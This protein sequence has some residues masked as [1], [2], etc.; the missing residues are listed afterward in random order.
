MWQ[1]RS[2]STQLPEI[3]SA[4]VG[5][6]SASARPS[7]PIQADGDPLT[8]LAR[9]YL[10]ASVYSSVRHDWRKPREQALVEKVREHRADAVIFCIAKFC[11]PALFD[12]VLFKQALER[13]KI[14]HLLVEFEE[15]MWTF[16]RVR[17]EIETFVESILFE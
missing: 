10:D 12:Y 7:A 11:E 4:P 13:E 15:K 16:E 9:A 17:N 5:W 8:A 2:S 1:A 14:P 3:I 6:P